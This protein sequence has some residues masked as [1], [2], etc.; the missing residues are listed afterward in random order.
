MN[1]GNQI[2]RVYVECSP[3]FQLLKLINSLRND[4][5]DTI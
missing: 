5:Y 3:L 4:L 1:N 2:S